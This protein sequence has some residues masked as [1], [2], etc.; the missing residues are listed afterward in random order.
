MVN[1]VGLSVGYFVKKIGIYLLVE[2]RKRFIFVLD[3]VE[4]FK[5]NE[6]LFVIDCLGIGLIGCFEGFV[7]G[8]LLII[9]SICGIVLV[10]Y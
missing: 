3:G 5:I 10:F 4:V 1:V 6:M 8:M 7:C 9:V 2:L